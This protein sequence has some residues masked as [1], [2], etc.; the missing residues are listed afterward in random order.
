MKQHTKPIIL[1][2]F[3]FFVTSCQTGKIYYR[4]DAKNWKNKPDSIQNQELEYSLFLIGDAGDATEKS[5][6]CLQSLQK[7]LT[8]KQKKSGVIFLGDNIYPRGLHKKNHPDRPED[9]KRLNAQ[10]DILKNFKGKAYF[11]AGNHDWEKSHEEGYKFVKRQEKYIEKYLNRGNIFLPDKACPGPE[12]V[13][14]TNELAVIFIDTQWLLHHHNKPLGEKDDCHVTDLDDFY[15]Q[16]KD[17][18]KKYRR[19]HVVVAGHHPLYSNGNHGGYFPFKEHIFPITAKK[20]KAY[21]PLPILGS[22]YPFYRKYFGHRQDIPHPVYQTMKTKL[23]SLFNEYENVIYSAGHEHNLQYVSKRKNHYILSGSGS[24]LTYLRHNRRIEFGAEKRGY[25]RLAFYKNADVWMEYIAPDEQSKTDQIIYRKFLYN[26]KIQ[27]INSTSVKKKSY[28]GQ[29]QIVTPNS[30][31]LA[32]K[33]K[34]FWFGNLHRDIW[35]LPI[36]V[37]VLDIHYEKGGLTPIKMGGGAQTHSLRL[38]GADGHQYVLRSIDKDATFLIGKEL[39]KTLVQ[40]IIYDG[41]AGSHPYASV[42]VPILANAVG[43]YHT[44]PK[45]IYVPKDEILGDYLQVFGGRFCLFE[46]R[47]DDDMSNFSSFGNSKKVVSYSKAIAKIHEKYS[48]RLD[49][50]QVLK[51]R[52]LDMLLA[53]WD[54]HDDQWR[55]ATFKTDSGTIY[56]P[57]PRDRDQVFFQFDGFFPAIMASRSFLPKFQTFRSDI[58]NMAG[59]NSQAKWFDRS[60][61]TQLGKKSWVEIAEKMQ[62]NLTDSVIENAIRKFPQPAFDKNGIKLISILKQRRD[63]LP[64]F[65]ERYYKILAKNVDVVGTLKRD[66]F[67]VKRLDKN[68]LEVNVYDL[69][70][71]KKGKRFYH[72]IFYRNETQEIRLYGL[73]G[74][75]KYHLKGD[76]N[77]SI[78]VRIIAGESNDKIKDESKVKSLRRK[79]V[80]YDTEKQELDKIQKS[81]ETKVILKPEKDAYT[82]DRKEF[83]YNKPLF[84]PLVSYN[85]DDDVSFGFFY[86]YTKYGF[87]KSPYQSRH[88]LQTRIAPAIEGFWISHRYERIKLIRNWNFVSDLSFKNPISFFYFGEGNNTTQELYKENYQLKIN[89]YQ[90]NPTLQIRSKNLFHFFELGANFRYVGFDKVKL[91]P[92]LS[93]LPKD[94]TFGGFTVR[95]FLNSADNE[96]NPYRGVKLDISTGWNRSIENQNVE[97]YF[98]RSQIA[99]YKPLYVMPMKTTLAFRVGTEH[100]FS[101]KYAFYQANFLNGNTNFRG[102]RRNRFAGQTSYYSNL[103]LRMNLV[104]IRNYYLPFSLGILA[105]ADLGKVSDLNEEFTENWHTS[106]GGGVFFNIL[107]AVTLVGTY[108][109]S[110]DDRIFLFSTKFLF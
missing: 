90:W 73:D 63:K 100:N 18:L 6:P 98:M 87:K 101:K 59:Q 30:T 88:Q 83:L 37:P 109:V 44:N 74:K 5:R 102:I 50:R 84:I 31:Y 103:D 19:K 69:E 41:I 20:K 49:E 12:V 54:R 26:K 17:L 23:L 95:Y 79:T 24:K 7:H 62:Q 78:L 21:V 92:A 32:S 36:E 93:T 45:L 65:A 76:V 52:F 22:V 48:H 80:I 35:T 70:D 9:E 39:R 42:V 28:A 10:L 82:L 68:R 106:S 107:D 15:L 46:E 105:H 4:S 38:K 97:F 72:R 89:D 81:S 55:W 66:F 67:E 56:R 53:D 13:E 99:F 27:K 77:R 60:F 58:N 11:I 94:E 34:R 51:S 16:L 8:E 47:P 14:M 104:K 91:T 57:I 96:L 25:V 108:S 29:T 71:G 33:F 64:E 1:L 75:D 110:D 2:L 85:V 86:Q 40:D 43:V 3:S 61:L